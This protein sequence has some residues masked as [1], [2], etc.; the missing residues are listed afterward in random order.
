[1]LKYIEEFKT[2][3]LVEKKRSENTVESYVNDLEQFYKYLS[4]SGIET[5]DLSRINKTNIMSYI[6]RLSASGKTSATV[7]RNIS[8][9]KAFYK[10]LFKCRIV[11]ENV[12]ESIS[13]P[14]VKKSNPD[15]LTFEEVELLLSK[16]EG[17]SEKA[18]RDMAMLET[19]YATGITVSELLDLKIS[20]VY[21]QLKFIKCEKKERIIPIGNKAVLAL[22]DYIENVRKNID[23]E[24]ETLFLNHNGEKM[25]RQ[26][27]WKLIKHYAK[28][29]GITKNITPHTVRHSFAVHLLKNGA[30]IHSVKEMLG[31]SDISST[32]IYLENSDLSLR[33]VYT[34]THPRN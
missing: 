28:I 21:L 7:S 24:D 11:N 26:G 22:E 30:N 4:E 31:H 10:Y 5:E 34:K 15:I 19:L 16:A 27:F 29:A 33:E 3:M 2:Y 8:S 23:Y 13:P 25:T 32:Q 20:D 18:K 6:L 17:E 9:I 1:M 12:P 14:K